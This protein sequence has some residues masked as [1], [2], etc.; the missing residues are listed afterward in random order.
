MYKFQCNRIEVREEDRGED[1]ALELEEEIRNC[2]LLSV[3]NVNPVEMFCW[4]SENTVKIFFLTSLICAIPKPRLK[5]DHLDKI[6]RVLG[7]S[8]M[9]VCIQLPSWC[10]QPEWIGLHP[11]K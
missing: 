11:K 6:C 7:V 10:Q 5:I 4:H 1:V 8:E 2:H 3:R 9:S